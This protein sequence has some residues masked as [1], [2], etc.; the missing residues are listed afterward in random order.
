LRIDSRGWLQGIRRLLAAS[1]FSCWR[2]EL[3]R[4]GETM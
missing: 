3:I 4:L 1:G 2:P